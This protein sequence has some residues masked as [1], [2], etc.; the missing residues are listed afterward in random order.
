MELARLRSDPGRYPSA[1]EEVLRYRPPV[2]AW[3]RVTAKDVAI[4]DQAIPARQQVVV[5]LALAEDDSAVPYEGMQAN[6]AQRLPLRFG[7]RR[8]GKG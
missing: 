6:G 8:A 2:N 4:G 1:I 3:F 5:F 7:A